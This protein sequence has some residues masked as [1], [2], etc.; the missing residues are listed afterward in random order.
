MVE[1]PVKIFLSEKFK[2][3]LVKNSDGP[4]EIRAALKDDEDV[5]KWLAEFQRKTQCTFIVQ[6]KNDAAQ[7]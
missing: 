1:S 3:V 2:A 4:L 5:K 6:R 7:K